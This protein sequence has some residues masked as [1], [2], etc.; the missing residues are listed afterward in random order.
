MTLLVPTSRLLDNITSGE[1]KDEPPF[2]EKRTEPLD[3]KW[4]T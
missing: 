1:T 3:L 2:G 4:A